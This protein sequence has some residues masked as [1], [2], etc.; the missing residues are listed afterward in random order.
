ML[1][2]VAWGFAAMP[3]ATRKIALAAVCALSLW[4]AEVLP[5]Q[6]R[7]QAGEVADILAQAK[8]GDLVVIC[9]DQLGPAVHRL[10]P[11]AGTQVVYPTFGSPA[12]V[13]WVDYAKRNEN[14]DANAFAQQALQRAAGHTI[15]YVYNIGYPTLAGGCSSLYTSFTIARGRPIEQLLP[16]GALEEESVEE[17]PAVPG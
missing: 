10:A 2:V 17:F 15:W 13:D 7:T 5:T 16:H 11:D 6:L 3:S 1:L 9:P 8:P 12:M 4:G 14:A